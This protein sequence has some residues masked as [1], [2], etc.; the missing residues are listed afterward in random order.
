MLE[1]ELMFGQHLRYLQ[2]NIENWAGFLEWQY[3]PCAIDGLECWNDAVTG[4]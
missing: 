1:C 4:V 2:C 3:S